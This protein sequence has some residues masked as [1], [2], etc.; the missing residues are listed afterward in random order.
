MLK[1]VEI[2][3]M[4]VKGALAPPCWSLLGWR[5]GPGALTGPRKGVR[6]GMTGEGTYRGTEM[7]VIGHDPLQ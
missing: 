4:W 6:M 2:R 7:R 1:S 5:L 3:I